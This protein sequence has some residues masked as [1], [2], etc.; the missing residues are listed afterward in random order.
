[1]QNSKS[2]TAS[3]T[4][5]KAWLIVGT[6]DI[7]S[8]FIWAY[9]AKERMPQDVLMGIGRFVVG[10]EI[11]RYDILANEG[12]MVGLG[13]FIHYVIAFCWTILFFLAWPKIP[14]LQGDPVLVGMLYGAVIWI[15]MNLGVR[16][17][18]MMA[19]PPFTFKG[20]AIDAA[21]LMIAIGIP[22]SIIIGNYYRNK[23]AA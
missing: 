7:C 1:M 4:I 23:E 12:L 20:V 3:M 8:A 2:Q 9:L 22:L 21:I 5:L 10:T 16:P 11:H 15:V 19:F 13:L 6:L 18:R 17:L 14:L